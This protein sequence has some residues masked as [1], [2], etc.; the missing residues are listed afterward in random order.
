MKA[1]HFKLIQSKIMFKR[2]EKSMYLGMKTS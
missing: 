1:T 2:G